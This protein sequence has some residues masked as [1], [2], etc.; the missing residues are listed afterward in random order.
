MNQSIKYIFL[1]NI[2]K[3]VIIG[4]YPLKNDKYIQSYYNKSKGI[5]DSIILTNEINGSIQQK[6]V[7]EKEI[8]YYTIKKSNIFY[9]IITPKSTDEN[10]AFPFIDEI[11]NCNIY[12]L[13]ND[14][15]NT[16]NDYGKNELKKVYIELNKN[17][18]LLS[19]GRSNNSKVDIIE[20]ELKETKKMVS[21]G[22]KDMIVNIDNLNDMEIKSS[23][24]K[25]SS[26]IVMNK[27]KK[28]KLNDIWENTKFKIFFVC[29]IIL[30]VIVLIIYVGSKK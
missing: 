5:F 18:T 10:T 12:L 6:K 22:I 19:T 27:S 4:T 15:T 14:K 23:A 20:N 25:N 21:N 26:T 24:I 7:I 2:D 17:P 28:L 3:K 13:V 11:E 29:L 16:L 30:I 9:L 8:F 1:G